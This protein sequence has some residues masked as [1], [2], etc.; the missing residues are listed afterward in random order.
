LLR[1]SLPCS[2]DS[3]L[4]A[5]LVPGPT[6]AQPRGEARRRFKQVQGETWIGAADAR[7]AP[8]W[9]TVCAKPSA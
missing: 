9:A 5:T 7:R 2:D 3:L 8:P 6:A 1:L 4:L